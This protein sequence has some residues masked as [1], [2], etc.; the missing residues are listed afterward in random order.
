MRLAVA[1]GKGGTGKTLLATSLA[2]FLADQG[3]RVTYAD[4]DVE[5]PNGHLFLHP[6]I[7]Q[8]T[9][10]KVLRPHLRHERCDAHGECQ[11]TCAFHAILSAKGRV[12]VFEELCHSCGACVLSCP[13]KALDEKERQIGVVSTG[14]ARGVDFVSGKLNVGEA[15]ATPLIKQVVETAHNRNEIV[16]VD[17]PPGTSCGPM[18]AVKGADLLL[19]VT[20]PTP[21]GLHDLELTVEMGRRLGLEL[22]AVINRADLGNDAVKNYLVRQGLPILAE[23]PFDRRIAEAYAASG[24]PVESCH[25]FKAAIAA[26]G[27]HILD[28]KGARP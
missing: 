28:G 7:H 4:A 27:K 5:E 12:I 6:T 24:L 2:R 26:I 14:T 25:E 15:R 18:A 22:A 20:E 8:C 21:F 19:L 10:S 9:Y 23:I 1:S 3:I 11:N 13:S 17:S 16:I